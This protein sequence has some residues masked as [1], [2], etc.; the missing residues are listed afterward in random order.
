MA[1]DEKEKSWHA[2]KVH[3]STLPGLA[4]MSK[5]TKVG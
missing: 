1:N 3:P 4:M 2:K 5:V